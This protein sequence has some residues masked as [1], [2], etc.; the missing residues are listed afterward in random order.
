M[1]CQEIYDTILL[2]YTHKQSQYDL[3][4]HKKIRRCLMRQNMHLEI[5]RR[6]I[7]SA[8]TSFPSEVRKDA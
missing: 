2:L 7:L 3:F 1:L 6:N 4:I 5:P 8:S